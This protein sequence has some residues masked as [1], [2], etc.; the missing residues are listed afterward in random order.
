MLLCD[1]YDELEAN[2][3][4]TND[5]FQAKLLALEKRQLVLERESVQLR[6]LVNDKDVEVKALAYELKEFKRSST[7][8]VS[9]FEKVNQEI[10]KNIA[11]LYKVTERHTEDASE[12]SEQ[13]V[14]VVK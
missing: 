8:T 14:G 9:C 3:K 12:K 13:L 4:L 10:I 6:K 5:C 7:K 2:N 1:K 11:E